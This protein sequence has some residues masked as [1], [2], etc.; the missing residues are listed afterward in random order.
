MVLIRQ[1]EGAKIILHGKV[2][3]FWAAKLKGFTV[4]STESTKSYRSVNHQAI[5]TLPVSMDCEH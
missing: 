5:K 3:T 2:P 1:N 4:M